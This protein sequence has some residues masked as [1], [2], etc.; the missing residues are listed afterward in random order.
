MA[1][2]RTS[3]GGSTTASGA[4]TVTTDTTPQVGDTILLVQGQDWDPISTMTTPNGTGWTQIGSGWDAGPYN[5]GMRMW[6]RTVTAAGE[7]S[8][9]ANG[10][11]GDFITAD[12]IVFVGGV[13]FGTPQG[14]A[15]AASATTGTAPS[16][17]GTVG[18]ILISA[19]MTLTFSGSSSPSVP[20]GMTSLAL[21]VNGSLGGLRV[22]QQALSAAGATGTR[23][24]NLGTAGN[25]N[26]AVSLPVNDPA[27]TAPSLEPGRGLLAV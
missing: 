17:V 22:A 4:L 5:P 1:A 14:A 11:S 9:T 2:I 26:V 6:T 7:Q 13:V 16:V 27:P 23:V 15:L 8:V 21:Y 20:S 3:N 25:G 24:S 19:F 12:V 18:G 10:Q